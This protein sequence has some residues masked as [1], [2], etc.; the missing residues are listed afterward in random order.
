MIQ[1]EKSTVDLE[2]LTKEGI[3]E[4]HFS[5]EKMTAWSPG[6]VTYEREDGVVF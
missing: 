6:P 1:N 5:N 3:A 4:T 2:T